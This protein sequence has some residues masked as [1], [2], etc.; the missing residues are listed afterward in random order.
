MPVAAWYLIIGVAVALLGYS[1]FH[2]FA[3][4]RH[5]AF[6]ARLR[7]S[8]QLVSRGEFVDGSRHL[9]A[10]LALTESAF[11]YESTDGQTSFDRKWIQ[12]VEYL[13][14][15]MLRV[16]FFSKTLEFLLS[17]PVMLQWEAILPAHSI[18]PVI[19]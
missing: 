18:A 3:D 5:A 8:S 1:V 6:T 10:A 16:R 7:D 13:N 11:I 12:Q 2:R 14:G 9:D 4:D 17:P 15:N 19:A